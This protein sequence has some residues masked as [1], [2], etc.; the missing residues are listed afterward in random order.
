[1]IVV[2]VELKSAISSSRDKLLGTLLITNDGTGSETRGNYD[3]LFR[4]AKGGSGKSGKVSEYPRNDVAI[5][6]LIRQACEVAGY[7]K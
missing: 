1:M 3:V 7:T 2:T 4:G 6:N 5:W